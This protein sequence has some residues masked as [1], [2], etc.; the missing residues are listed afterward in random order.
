[1]SRNERTEAVTA[2]CAE[3]E[4]CKSKIKKCP[5]CGLWDNYKYAQAFFFVFFFSSSSSSFYFLWP[6]LSWFLTSVP[7]VYPPPFPLPHTHRAFSF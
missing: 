1:M 7:T 3:H 4:G 6:Q 5:D 2:M